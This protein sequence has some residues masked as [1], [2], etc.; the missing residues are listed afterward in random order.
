MGPDELQ[1]LRNE[2]AQALHD[3]HGKSENFHRAMEAI[4]SLQA[5]L[6]AANKA[7]DDA[8]KE[9]EGMRETIASL[10]NKHQ[11]MAI[12]RLEQGLE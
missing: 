4:A 11:T 10:R 2:N 9:S 8:E 12:L 7:K 5:E 1:R 3:L 6:D